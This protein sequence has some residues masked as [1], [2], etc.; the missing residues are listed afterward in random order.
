MPANTHH[1]APNNDVASPR[2]MR[3]PTFCEAYDTSRAT[4]YRAIAAGRIR[5]VKCGRATLIDVASAEAWFASLPEA[6]I[7]T[8]SHSPA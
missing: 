8:G 4:A 5:A 7:G 3:L 6:T 2:F 1:A